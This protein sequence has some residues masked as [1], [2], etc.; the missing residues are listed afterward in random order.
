[1][2]T[3]GSESPRHTVASV[4]AERAKAREDHGAVS[5]HAG[6]VARIVAARIVA[7]RSSSGG[8]R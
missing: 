3:D 4:M 7:R 5:A 2:T 6:S 1:M 8:G